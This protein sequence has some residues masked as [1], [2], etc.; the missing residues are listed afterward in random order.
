MFR[1]MPA[2][3]FRR[4]AT[5]CAAALATTPQAACESQTLE[6]HWGER[7][8]AERTGWHQKDVNWIVAQFGAEHLKGRILV[9]LC[10]KTVDMPYLAEQPGTV[11]VVGVEGVPKALSEF[12]EEHSLKW[13]FDAFGGFSRWQTPGDLGRG[14]LTL[15]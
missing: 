8:Q 14:V 2:P 5:L 10:G 12:R 15:L 13:H 11:E 1:L 9:P 4:C 3:T 6:S 7:W